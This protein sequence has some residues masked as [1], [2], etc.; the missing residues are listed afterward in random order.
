MPRGSV[1]GA[2]CTR[3]RP[4]S[5]DASCV[6][7]SRCALVWC[8]ATQQNAG[9]VQ[10]A[11]DDSKEPA[12]ARAVGKKRGRRE[13]LFPA[14]RSVRLLVR[15]DRGIHGDSRGTR[16]A[17]PDSIETPFR[18]RYRLPAALPA[19]TRRGHITRR[20]RQPALPRCSIATVARAFPQSS[21]PHAATVEKGGASL[22]AGWSRARK[23]IPGPGHLLTRGGKRTRHAR[24]SVGRRQ[25]PSRG[26]TARP[27]LTGVRERS[28]LVPTRRR[29]ARP[30][31]R[32]R[33]IRFD[34]RE[35]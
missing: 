12:S 4:R 14:G 11:P 10:R 25:I 22:A 7:F 23:A 18:S 21:A 33:Q 31:R 32:L 13:R 15:R 3:S 20:L 9:A 17:L 35:L 27:V 2:G 5:G 6:S 19:A 24:Q 28:T 1:V 34:R 16:A 8:V 30:R 26:P 29:R